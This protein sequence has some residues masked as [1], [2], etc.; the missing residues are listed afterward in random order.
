MEQAASQLPP[1]GLEEAETDDRPADVQVG[2]IMDEV[3]VVLA[4]RLKSSVISGTADL[5][6]HADTFRMLKDWQVARKKIN[7]DIDPED[8]SALRAARDAVDRSTKRFK[9]IGTPKRPVYGDVIAGVSPPPKKNGAPTLSER[10]QKAEYAK[11][12]QRQ[13]DKFDGEDDSEMKR[14][15]KA[16]GA[17]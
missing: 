11:L 5:K 15:L 7:K 12:L 14:K 4:R 1:C 9:E 8:D 17:I 10:E 2:E 16:V 3:A 13:Q 6:T